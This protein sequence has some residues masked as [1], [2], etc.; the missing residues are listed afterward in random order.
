MDKRVGILM[1]STRRL[2]GLIR[3]KQEAVAITW[4]KVTIPSADGVGP[5]LGYAAF[6]PGTWLSAASP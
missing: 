2:P 1:R 5:H 4:V 3:P 6:G